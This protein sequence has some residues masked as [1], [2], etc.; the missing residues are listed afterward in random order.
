M[1]SERN[2]NMKIRSGIETRN[3]K[4]KRHRNREKKLVIMK[5][6]NKLIKSGKKDR[7]CII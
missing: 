5:E 4:L 1:K 3:N 2:Q 6:E 7:I